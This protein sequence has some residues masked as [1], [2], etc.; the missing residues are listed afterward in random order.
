MVKFREY[1]ASDIII[2]KDDKGESMFFVLDGAA[3]VISANGAIVYAELPVNTFFGEVS[4]FFEVNR[5]ATVRAKTFTTVIELSKS[6][7][8]TVLDQHS[9]LRELILSKANENYEV[10]KKRQ[11]ISFVLLL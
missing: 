8:K 11:E 5:T 2:K 1:R 10:Y 6:A 3:E 9:E 7:L 4:L